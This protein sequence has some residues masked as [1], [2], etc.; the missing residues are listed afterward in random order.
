[1]SIAA[2]GKVRLSA[3]GRHRASA[4]THPGRRAIAGMVLL[5]A[6]ALPGSALMAQ[7]GS[8]PA[9]SVNP[10]GN[11]KAVMLAMVPVAQASLDL[12]KEERGL[13]DDALKNRKKKALW[14][15]QQ[16]DRLLPAIKVLNRGIDA[17][18]ANGKELANRIRRYNAACSGEISDRTKYEACKREAAR[19]KVERN[20][21]MDE[22]RTLKARQTKLKKEWDYYDGLVRGNEKAIA[23]NTRRLSKI[24]ELKNAYF[25]RLDDDRRTLVSLCNAAAG[26]EGSIEYAHY[27]QSIAWDGAQMGLSP[28]TVVK[29]GTQFFN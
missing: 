10:A 25:R 20:R 16:S 13:K 17:H 27:C 29:W 8:A 19:L 5:G 23:D 4:L 7:T 15:G 18:N 2:P 11:V 14:K 21:Y 6:L 12:Q 1:M 24:A 3:F 22:G 28:L 26:G 9:D